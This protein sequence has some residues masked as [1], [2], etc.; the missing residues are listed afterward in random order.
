MS[1]SSDSGPGDISSNSAFEL[2]KAGDKFGDFQIIECIS[3]SILGTLYHV[4]KPLK[5]TNLS[6]YVLPA[7]DL[8]DMHGNVREW[9]M[10]YYNARLPGGEQSDWYQQRENKARSVR[11]GGWQ[12]SAVRSRS[13]ARSH[14]QREDGTSSATYFR[15]IALPGISALCFGQ[16]SFK[17]L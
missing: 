5:N 4:S 9:C 1:D 14:I 12:G 11:G 6:L 13:A 2:L 15:F 3:N 10:D 7:L 8:I 16:V 17:T